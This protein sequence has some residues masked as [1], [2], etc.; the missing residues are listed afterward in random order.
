MR[1]ENRLTAILKVVIDRNRKLN[2][3]VEPYYINNDFQPVPCNH[4]Y[5]EVEKLNGKLKYIFDIVECAETEK[6]E[7]EIIKSV[8]REHN[9]NRLRMRVL[10]IRYFYRYLKGIIGLYKYVIKKKTFVKPDSGH[11]NRF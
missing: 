8:E 4:I 5:E 10:M 1:N 11:P 3:E 6:L 9:K 7:K 2:F